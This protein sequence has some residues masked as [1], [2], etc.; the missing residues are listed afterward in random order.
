MDELY[1]I[2]FFDKAFLSL[3]YPHDITLKALESYGDAIEV[4]NEIDH[5]L[6]IEYCNNFLDEKYNSTTIPFLVT[7]DLRLYKKY[8]NAF[9]EVEFNAYCVDW[10]EE[11][12]HGRNDYLNYISRNSRLGGGYGE[13]TFEHF[14]NIKKGVYQ[15]AYMFRTYKT[16]DEEATGNRY[17][18][19]DNS[20]W[21][22]VKK[23]KSFTIKDSQKVGENLFKNILVNGNNPN[24][25]YVLYTD[26]LNEIA[27]TAKIDLSMFEFEKDE[28]EN[29]SID[30]YI[31]KAKI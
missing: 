15:E 18:M 25:E 31:L 8:R 30:I 16:W 22:T 23:S 26:R 10:P 6:D 4:I 5:D 9:T 7:N 29:K 13:I 3:N 17:K 21:K 27:K 2:S 1:Y 12:A 19:E 20:G 28:V 11:K 24:R 14:L